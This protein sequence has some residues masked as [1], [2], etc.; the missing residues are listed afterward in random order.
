MRSTGHSPYDLCMESGISMWAQR[1]RRLVAA[2]SLL[3]LAGCGA[4]DG[5]AGIGGVGRTPA[6]ITPTP[7]L[8]SASAPTALTAT[9]PPTPATVLP[10]ATPVPAPKR[11]PQTTT[12]VPM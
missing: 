9:A 11:Q 8:T 5:V 6:A 12:P 4:A 1:T 3:A 2:A 7:T 10:A